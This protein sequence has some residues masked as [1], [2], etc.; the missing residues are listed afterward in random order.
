MENTPLLLIVQNLSATERT[1]ARKWLACPLFNQRQDALLLFEELCRQRPATQRSTPPPL[2]KEVV[3]EIL[4]EEK[5]ATRRSR[6]GAAASYS[7]ASMRLLMSFLF[8]ALKQ[9]LAWRKW[10]SDPLEQQ[11]AL[12]AAL[13]ERGLDSVFQKE[14]KVLERQ[15]EKTPW[16]NVHW[17]GQVFRS[18]Q[19]FWASASH[20]NRET[21][22]NIAELNHAFDTV[23][24]LDALRLAC[25]G[26]SQPGGRDALPLALPAV[27]AAVQEGSFQD[28][29]AI[30]VYFHAYKTQEQSGAAAEAHFRQLQQLL[31][32]H[33]QQFPPAE[34]RDV[35]M[36]A[37][38]F[39]IR[40]VNAGSRAYLREAFHL[41]RSGIERRLLLDDG[42]LSRF[43]YNNALL[44]AI[45]LEEWSVAAE[46][47]HQYRH[48]LPPKDR[49]SAWLYNSAVFYFRKKDY[50]QAQEILRGMDF[51]DVFYNLDARRMLAR[52]YTENGETDAL[53]SL[54]DSFT[55]YLQRKRASLDYH[56]DLNM[57]FIRFLKKISRLHPGD[58]AG[59]QALGEKIRQEK[60]VAEREWLLAICAG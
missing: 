46:L 39:C 42:Y 47:L 3:W 60:Y 6:S 8:T 15:L 4:F 33:W 26:Y 35:F 54:L 51:R 31:D 40:Q 43:T 53:D 36:I 38:N 56:K 7:D 19:V 37:L 1:E 32:A 21:G 13:K 11:L 12:C 50:A 22:G 34:I 28:N 27:L 9:W 14:N 57:H 41:Y 18:K 10:A 59:R 48:W 16:R 30:Q 44:A 49:E 20:Q 17:A 45:A 25:T 29:P 58:N 24:A 23:V 55:T 52:I 5:R 2:H